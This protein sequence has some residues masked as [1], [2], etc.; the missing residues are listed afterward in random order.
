MKRL[1]IYCEGQTEEMFVDRILRNHLFHHGVKVENPILAATSLTP[2]GQRGGFVNWDA[3]E[4][5]LRT[6]FASD[7]DPNLRFTTLLD[8]YAM[9]AK[10]LQL[11]GFAGPISTVADIVAVEQKIEADFCEPRFKAYLQRH[12]F[13]ALLLADLDALEKVFHRHQSGIQQLRADI[14]SFS[15]PEEINHG[16]TTHPSA[17]L[18]TAITGYANLKAL[19]AYWVIAEAGLETARSKCPRFNDWLK[20]WEDWGMKS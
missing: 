18:A 4:F 12:E 8:S 6:K 20:Y 11:C 7:P 5:D 17:R 16:S 15:G 19:N 2:R 13:E 3:I 10:I 9:P 1:V 14:A